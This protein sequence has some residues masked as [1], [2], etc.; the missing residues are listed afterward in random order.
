MQVR[1]YVGVGAASVLLAGAAWMGLAS[2]TASGSTDNNAISSGGDTLRFVATEVEVTEIDLGEAGFSQGDQIVFADDLLRGGSTFGTAG[3]VCTLVRA[4]GDP[5][6][7]CEVTYR[8]P[9]GAITGHALLRAS[10][11]PVVRFAITGGTAAFDEVAGQGRSLLQD[12]APVVLHL[13][14]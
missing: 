3:G 1:K 13:E 11:L 2:A 8:L 7:S 9:R 14:D 6:Y 5:E 4:S 10:E 12:T